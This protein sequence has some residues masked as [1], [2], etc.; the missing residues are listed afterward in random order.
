M[1]Q[2]SNLMPSTFFFAYVKE[3]G[4]IFIVFKGLAPKSLNQGFDFC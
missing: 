1:F 2:R 4:Y 3:R